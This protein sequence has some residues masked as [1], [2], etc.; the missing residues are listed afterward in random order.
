MRITAARVRE[1]LHYDPATGIFTHRIARRGLRYRIG[2]IAG[3]IS[4]EDGG[5]RIGLEGRRYW[6]NQIAWLY[7]TGEWPSSDVDHING[8]RSDDRFA[9][10]RI[11][12]RSE[13]LANARRPKHNTSGLKGA[14]WHAKAG[15]WRATIKK[16]R[17]PIHIGYFDSAAEAHSAY[18]AKAK[19][20]FGEFA[21]A[22]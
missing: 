5:R 21:R 16:N 9:N 11:A 13:N 14:N 3:R 8:M 15:K 1:L 18:L 6:G 4:E 12:T 17:I 10:L 7:V 22:A 20:L 2:E 19:E